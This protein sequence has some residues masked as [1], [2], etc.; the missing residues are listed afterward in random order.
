LAQPQTSVSRRASHSAL[1][2]AVAPS[3]SGRL[4]RTMRKGLSARS[5]G[6]VTS[7]LA[8][9]IFVLASYQK[10][11]NELRA[12]PSPQKD[13]PVRRNVCRTGRVRS[14]PIL[15]GYTINMFE[16][17]FPT[18]TRARKRRRHTQKLLT[19]NGWRQLPGAWKIRM[20]TRI[21]PPNCPTGKKLD[22]TMSC[23]G[24]GSTTRSYP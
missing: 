18:G 11:D 17:E 9:A 5:D 6:N 13:A 1:G 14:S 8:S 16:F 19:V 4:G 23:K 10:Y 24:R 20:R 2:W 22:L 21:V 3:H 7:S 15:G 12:H